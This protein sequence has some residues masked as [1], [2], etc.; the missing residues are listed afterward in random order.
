MSLVV[1]AFL[2]LIPALTHPG[3]QAQSTNQRDDASGSQD[4]TKRMTLTPRAE[5]EQSSRQ[6]KPKNYLPDCAQPKNRDEADLCEQ[7]RMAEAAKDTVRVGNWQVGVGIGAAI[8]SCLAAIFTAW[9]AYA[10]SQAAKASERS[11]DVARDALVASQRAW[12]KRDRIFFSAP[13]EV[14]DDGLLHSTVGFEF[15]NVGIAPALHVQMEAWLLPVTRGRIPE[16][17][18]LALFDEA[19]ARPVSRGFAL[20]PGESYPR[21]GDHPTRDGVQMT[22][23]EVEAACDEH[24]RLTLYLA[25]CIS[26]AFAS[27]PKR[28]H[29]TSCLF[30]VH[31]TGGFITR[32]PGEIN[33]ADLRL[34]E[35]GFLGMDIAD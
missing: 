23:E 13:L 9:A 27:D 22:R 30:E 32:E 20:F 12:I 8:V 7:M 14:R 1:L 34:E 17:R 6:S 26:Y 35:S 21:H 19:R 5:R 25:A 2:V 29:Q 15:T 10:A 33:E 4:V 24:G 11:V 31:F 3:A 28:Y 16:D 18:A